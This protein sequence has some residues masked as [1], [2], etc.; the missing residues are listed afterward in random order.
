MLSSANYVPYEGQKGLAVLVNLIENQI[1]VKI[2]RYNL[3][4]TYN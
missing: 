1:K 4:Y 2:K 3:N